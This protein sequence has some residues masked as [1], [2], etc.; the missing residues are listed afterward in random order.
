MDLGQNNSEGVLYPLY[1]FSMDVLYL[2]RRNSYRR[3]IREELYRTVG[4]ALGGARVERL[5]E[6]INAVR[7]ICRDPYMRSKASYQPI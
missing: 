4:E 1:M 6:A 3:E 7:N 2:L 5:S